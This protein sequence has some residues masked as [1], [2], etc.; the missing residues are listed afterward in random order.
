M[1]HGLSEIQASEL[2]N[3]FLP[4]CIQQ[5]SDRSSMVIAVMRGPDPPQSQVIKT[6]GEYTLNLS[7][8]QDTLEVQG[9]SFSGSVDF[10]PMTRGTI[11]TP[12]NESEQTD[13][14][15]ENF[16]RLLVAYRLLD[17]NG[18]L[19]HSAA[20]VIAGGAYLFY[21][22]S[23]AGKSTLS[24]MA[25]KAGFEVI[26][27]DLNAV[28]FCGRRAQVRKL[29][30][31]GTF[32][33]STCSQEIYPLRGIFRLE[34]ARLNSTRQPGMAVSLAS[35][36]SCTPFVNAST[37]V[38]DQLQNRLLQLYD[39]VEPGILSFSKTSDFNE[40]ANLLESPNA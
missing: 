3:R 31:T 35:L 34:K 28:Q 10:G 6:S 36:L 17:G 32:A 1:F 37:A 7:H 26:S 12:V 33:E 9:L 22:I 24:E 5:G 21:G 20:I 27:D 2:R 19:V 11:L 40:I 18:V 30:F 38:L 4:Y 39:H 16:L 25:A 29:P 15:F 23:G 14:I 8:H 13:S